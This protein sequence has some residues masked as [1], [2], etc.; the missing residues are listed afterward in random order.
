MNNRNARMDEFEMSEDL[1]NLTWLTTF[2]L[3]KSNGISHKYP[4]SLSPPATPSSPISPLSAHNTSSP[5]DDDESDSNRPTAHTP[6]K[7][8]AIW[9][10]IA[11]LLKSWQQ[12]TPEMGNLV[13]CD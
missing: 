6:N 1:T 3:A 11:K 2:N 13:V 9:S 12:R 7:N 5:E 8:S 4:L 10:F